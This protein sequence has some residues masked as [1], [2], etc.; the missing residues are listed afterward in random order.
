GR[1]GARTR[2]RGLPASAGAAGRDRGTDGGGGRPAGERGS[3]ADPRAGARRGAPAVVA[4]GGDMSGLTP[5]RFE[6]LLRWALEGLARERSVFGLPVRSFWSG[7][8]RC[9]L[10][11]AM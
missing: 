1:G 8:G 11:I 2:D 7:A 6:A 5:A 4:H 10:S 3:R 9:D